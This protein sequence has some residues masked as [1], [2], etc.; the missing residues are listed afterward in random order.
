M[1]QSDFEKITLVSVTG[2]H[3]AQ[4]AVYALTLSQRNMPGARVLLCSP[5][6]PANLPAGIEHRKIAPLNYH[7][8]SWFM[9]FALWRVIETEFALIVQDDGWVLDAANWSSDFLQYDYIGP[10]IH[11]GCVASEAGTCWLTH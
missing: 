3:D 11:V 6:S 2:L 8:Y 1:K 5:Q 9:M 7:E 4:R 10:M